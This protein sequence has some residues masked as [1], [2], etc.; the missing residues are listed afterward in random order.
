[1]R[2][3]TATFSPTKESAAIATRFRLPVSGIQIALR[4]P[5]GTDDVLIA[6]ADIKDPGLVLAV[7][8][9][10]GHAAP[11]IDWAALTLSDLDAL[12]L[13]LRQALYGNR[14]VAETTC[15]ASACGSPIDISFAIEAYLIH[16][17]PRGAPLHG[18]GWTVEPCSEEAGWFCVFAAS[19]SRE[20]RF[21]LPTAADQLSV[22]GRADAE[23]ALARLCIRPPELPA[24]LRARVETVMAAMA[25]R[26][27]SELQG[28]CP[29]CGATVTARF[30][31][32]RYCLQEMRDR[33][34]F[35]YDDID[36]LAHRY[37]WSERAILSMPNARRVSYAELARQARW[38]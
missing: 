5:T 25:P 28:T 34:H 14:I 30:E 19:Q 3:R 15:Q 4:H 11:T 29:N 36:A 7:A 1:M 24:R 26:L 21:R 9:R 20:V 10:L 2:G 12:I 16:H 6:E 23:Q 38:V 8:R 27:D 37:H 35:V 32:R 18:R 13:R 33:A 17:S 22:F 31:A